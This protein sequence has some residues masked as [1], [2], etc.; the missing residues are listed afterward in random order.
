M[1]SNFSNSEILEQSS[2]LSLA[3]GCIENKDLNQALFYCQQSSQ[4]QGSHV[5]SALIKSLMGV[6]QIYSEN[7]VEAIE[8]FNDGI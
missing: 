3:L 2:I 6:I 5:S 7:Y 1:L 8:Q 4:V